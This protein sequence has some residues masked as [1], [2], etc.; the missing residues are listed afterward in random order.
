MREAGK[1]ERFF[2]MLPGSPKSLDSVAQKV[3]AGFS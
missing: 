1:K 2:F 3:S